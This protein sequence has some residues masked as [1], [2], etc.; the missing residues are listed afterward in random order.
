MAQKRKSFKKSFRKNIRSTRRKSK[1]YK[2][3]KKSRGGEDSSNESDYEKNARNIANKIHELETLINA[4]ETNSS[5]RDDAN[6]K[7]IRDIITELLEPSS[8]FVNVMSKENMVPK[9]VDLSKISERAII[10]R[11]FENMNERYPPAKSKIYRCWTLG[12]ANCKRNVEDLYRALIT[13]LRW[14]VQKENAIVKNV[15][16]EDRLRG[17]VGG[18]SNEQQYKL[19]ELGLYDNTEEGIKE[20]EYDLT[21][22]QVFERGMKYALNR[23]P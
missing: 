5:S 21:K 13:D 2:K 14:G 15:M 1:T 20:L 4:W 10:I 17:D 7:K 18:N 19:V 11:E 6:R 23:M 22:A 3:S 8:E 16:G 12:D 9:A